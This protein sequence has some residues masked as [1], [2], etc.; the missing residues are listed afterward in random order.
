MEIRFQSLDGGP[1]KVYRHLAY[2]LADAYLTDDPHH[3]TRDPS[4]LAHLVAKGRVSAMTRAASHLLW[5][6]EFTLIRNYLTAH[7]EWMPSDSTGVPPPFAAAAGLEQD[8]Y[9]VF[10][11]AYEPSDQGERRQ[12][13]DAFRELF[14]SNPQK[15]LDFLFGYPDNAKNAHLVVTYRP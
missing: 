9:G 3:L 11:A 2:N 8:T 15:R 14:A 6:D 10:T 12:Y 13:N 5:F 1:I 7:L 4:L